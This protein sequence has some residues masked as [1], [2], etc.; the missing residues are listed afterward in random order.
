MRA[1]LKEIVGLLQADRT[2]KEVAEELGVSIRTVWKWKRRAVSP[3]T[4]RLSRHQAKRRSTKPKNTSRPEALSRSQKEKIKELR[5]ESAWRAERLGVALGLE[6]SPSTSPAR[7][8][9]FM[10]P[11]PS[12]YAKMPR[13][14]PHWGFPR[15]RKPHQ[16]TEP[17]GSSAR[18]RSRDS[19]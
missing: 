13:K 4:L 15:L 18:A 11:V 12:R 10:R 14:L 6:V 8:L 9:F 16:K 2:A 5:L 19:M 17:F 7:S 3:H 1:N